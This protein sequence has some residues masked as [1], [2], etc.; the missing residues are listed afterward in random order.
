MKVNIEGDFCICSG[1]C[2]LEAPEVFGQDDNGHVV[3][4]IES[5][6]PELHASV[7]NAEANCPA[8]VIQ[9]LDD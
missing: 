8:S 1:S 4:L 6:S 5:P 7:R 3:V 9:L 2:V